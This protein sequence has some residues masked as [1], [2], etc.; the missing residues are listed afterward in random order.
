MTLQPRKDGEKPLEYLTRN[1]YEVRWTQGGVVA[2]KA[3]EFWRAPT[4]E[5]MAQLVAGDA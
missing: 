4:V 1:G 2:E 5:A 3:K